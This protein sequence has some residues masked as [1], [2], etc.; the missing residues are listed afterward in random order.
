LKLG[1]KNKTVRDK[2][3]KLK[4]KKKF[5]ATSGWSGT[6]IRRKTSVEVSYSMPRE[7]ELRPVV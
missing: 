5:E 7:R 3:K 1:K 4:G 2:G 6:E